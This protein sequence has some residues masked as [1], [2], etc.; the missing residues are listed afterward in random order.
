MSP[1]FYL[2]C[3]A[4]LLMAFFFHANY[5]LRSSY[6]SIPAFTLLCLFALPAIRR[7]RLILAPGCLR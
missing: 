5:G 2:L 7:E 6:A 3:V 1:G 4:A